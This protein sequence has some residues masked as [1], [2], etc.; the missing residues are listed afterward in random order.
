MTR[1][2]ISLSDDKTAWR[3]A[4]AHS[5]GYFARGPLSAVDEPLLA[6]LRAVAR[7]TH[8]NARLSLH[9]SPDASFHE[10]VIYQHADRIHPPKKHLHKDKSFHIIEGVLAVLIFDESGAMTDCCLLDGKRRHMYRVAAGI[11]HADIPITDHVI[12]HESTMGPF[13]R[14]TDSIFAPWAPADTDQSALDAYR[15][16]LLAQIDKRENLSRPVLVTGASG[17]CGTHVLRRL[18]RTDCDLAAIYRHAPTGEPATGAPRIIE[19][20]LRAPENLPPRLRAVVHAA[21]HLGV[22]G[23]SSSAIAA[24]NVEATRHLIEHAISA[25]ADK[26]IFFSAMSIYG[27]VTAS[28]VNEGTEIRNPDAYGASKL[29]G[30]QMLAECSRQLPS[31]SLRLPSI[32]A[33]DARYGWI[34]G[35]VAKL[36]AHER[37][38]FIN[39]ETPFNNLVHADDLADFVVNLIEQ[40]FEGAQVVTLGAAEPMKIGD[41]V[42]H[43]KQRLSSKSDVQ[44]KIQPGTPA[45]TIDSS[46]ASRRFGW[47]PARVIDILDR[48]ADEYL[49]KAGA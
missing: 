38:T 15:R 42:T 2:S 35:L 30:E 6:E 5:V 43:L 22:P 17:L 23:A 1:S 13:V 45:F 49:A 4:K 21:A 40:P 20:D 39:P 29:L 7:E 10:M 44:A 9:Q 37:I 12:H 8:E 25:G 31:V 18:A 26:F 48:L 46:L 24:D 27:K 47:K 41:V 32:V 33:S 34:T 11:Y 36:M 14:A 28:T 3:D 16:H 19:S